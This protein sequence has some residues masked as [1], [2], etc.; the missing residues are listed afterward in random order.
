MQNLSVLDTREFLI[1]HLDA[2]RALAAGA[3]PRE[4][5]EI[6]GESADLKRR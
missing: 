3:P 2:T 6:L 5:T 4:L 1:S